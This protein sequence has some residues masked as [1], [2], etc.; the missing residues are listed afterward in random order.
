MN[1]P[2]RFL[3]TDWPETIIQVR[4]GR[5]EVHGGLFYSE[6]RS[7][8]FD[9]SKDI[10]PLNAVL[11]VKSSSL[12]L[13]IQ[14][15]DNTRIGVTR[16]SF[17]HSYL[18]E[19]YP[20]LQF[21]KYLNNELMIMAAVKGE[22][23]AFAADYPVAL[24][25]I[26]RH[27]SPAYFRP[28]TPLYTRQLQ[29]GVL[30]GDEKLLKQVNQALSKISEEEMRRMTQRWMRSEIV[31]VMPGWVIPLY[32]GTSLILLL[33]FY[34]LIMRRKSIILEGKF[35]RKA[36]DLTESQARFRK[37]FEHAV[38]GVAIHE[39]VLNND[40]KPVDFIFLNTNPAF[41]THTGIKSESVIGKHASQ[42]LPGID[43]SELMDIYGNVVLTG[44]PSSLEYYY[45][46]Q[47]KH[48][49]INAF[50]IAENQFATVFTNI[51]ERKKAEQNI[52]ENRAFLNSL[53][54]SIPIPVFY[55][56]ISGRYL[57]FNKAF[58]EFFGK[59]SE[60]LIGKNVFD[61]SPAE[62]ARQ[63]HQ[64]DLEVFDNPDSVQRY[65]SKVKNAQ[66]Q[67]MSV[68]FQKAAL[69]DNA[70]KVMGLIG[71]VFDIT[72]LKEMEKS[73]KY[74][75]ARQKVIARVS[76]SFINSNRDNIDEK[77]DF[78]LAVCGEFL[79]VDRAYLFKFSKDEKFLTNTH[80][81]CA[82]GI[83]PAMEV[84]QD[85]PLTNTPML[86]EK[87][88]NRETMFIP[89]VEL[90]PDIPDKKVLL[91][92][93]V[94]TVLCAPLIEN[95]ALIGYLGFDWVKSACNITH[96][97]HEML[98]ILGNIL[99]DALVKVEIEE[100]ML[101]AR[102]QAEAASMAKS[103][104]LANMSHE[105]RT[106]MNAITGMIHLARRAN[107]D[108]NILNYLDK[109]DTSASSLLGILNDILDFSKIEAGK[110]ELEH[111]VFSIHQLMDSL[112]DIVGHKARDKGLALYRNI[113]AGIPEKYYGDRTRLLQILLNLTNNAIK[114][115]AQGEVR[116]LV[117][118]LNN[119][120]ENSEPGNQVF[121][122]F[123]VADT[124]IGMEQEKTEH[125]FEAFTQADASFTRKYGGTGLGLAISKQLV[126]MMK[127]RIE[128]HSTPGK[129]SI[130]TFQ[131]QLETAPD[132]AQLENSV[133]VPKFN[134]CLKRNKVLL[135]EDNA[136]N[137]ELAREFIKDVGAQV[138]EAIDG[139]QGVKLALAEDFDLILMDIQMPEMNGI[140]AT[141]KI[142]S[143]ENEKGKS[144]TPIIAMTAHAMAEDRERS[145]AAGMDD[146][147]TKPID[148][149]K[150][151]RMLFKH[152]GVD[153]YNQLSMECS[154]QWQTQKSGSQDQISLPS[155]V[156]PLNIQSALKRTND[157][158]DLLI[159]MLANFV[160][161]YENT[162]EQMKELFQAEKYKEAGIVVHTL[163]GMAATLEAEEITSAAQN[164]ENAL[165]DNKMENL[166]SL[167][168][169]LTKELLPAVN[170]ARSVVQ[171]NKVELEKTIVNQDQPIDHEQAQ[172]YLQELKTLVQSSNFRARK[173]FEVNRKEFTT[174]ENMQEV[175]EIG[176]ALNNLD[177]SKA[178]KILQAL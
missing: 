45:A 55:K 106:P 50:K 126:E 128:V 147:L 165:A 53:L 2:V 177:F 64:K 117:K 54:N 99:S 75:S 123:S 80:E 52:R 11:F 76:S 19:N 39:I 15:L 14:D 18:A 160:R 29:A 151:Y 65:E 5:A 32:V 28:L 102:Q 110:L 9:F 35:A 153:D 70:G 135:V 24:Y 83:A 97:E 94:R 171:S 142:R 154:G 138:T 4:D 163:K 62:L 92:Q 33:L 139:A 49:F 38:S 164:L 51:T 98:N 121:L 136:S 178:L 7:L 88:H 81:W 109:I 176:N 95:E 84:L 87:V 134:D 79:G 42:V 46:D 36:R 119:E 161:D 137:R 13:E 30:K 131:V 34:A 56:D 156:P 82:P 90:L 60:D 17:E 96:E 22:I 170:A 133:S 16:G 145:L 101:W 130:F 85:F 71:A 167:L 173:Y 72:Q 103:E 175:Q 146:H 12:A 26:D 47:G 93:D 1:R 91:E 8:F 27:A 124:G 144:R 159:R 108:E 122:E 73:L 125:L 115:T 140:E 20:F 162:S 150:F 67:E 57:G 111:S 23:E 78:M 152:L 86:G 63:Y 155:M 104:F 21:E 158:T 6:E 3:L 168:D 118:A 172:K 107:P 143:F 59:S 149:Q 31:E 105:I 61:I 129:G 43:K 48:Y 40:G 41:E 120:Q 69:F 157:K 100:E 68:I 25:L 66:G 166:E 148:P 58:E 116:V 89:D 112:I 10:L 77:I 37:L 114:F 174:P 132:N 141:R 74:Q 169:T 113:E 127:G 44:T